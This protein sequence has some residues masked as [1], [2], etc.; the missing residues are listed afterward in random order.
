MA[1]VDHVPLFL[2]PHSKHQQVQRNLK[3]AQRPIVSTLLGI[4]TDVGAVQSL[5]ARTSDAAQRHWGSTI[6][7]K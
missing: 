6:V 7:G 5:N 1:N 4:V 2:C 3:N